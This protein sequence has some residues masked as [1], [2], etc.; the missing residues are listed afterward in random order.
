MT[1][2]ETITFLGIMVALAAMPSTS[3][4]LVVT[5]SAT[6]GIGNG[7]AV[8]AGIVLG[9]L[10]FIMLALFGLS[11]VAETMGSLFMVVK[12][13][14]AMYLIWLGFLLL[15]TKNTTKIMI[16]RPHEKGN[17][18][19]SFVAGFTLTL[20]DIKAIFFYVSLLPMF[21]NLAALQVADIIVVVFVTV[22][23]VGGVKIVYALTSAKI[24]SLANNLK[25]DNAARK[26]A[27]GFMVGAGGYIIAKA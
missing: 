22:A 3:V 12:Y 21:I 11:A 19:V 1:V 18:I 13:L 23:G 25:F 7:I 20:G 5:R 4:A 10:V 27:G 6:L 9:D 24:A 17:L 16:N 26:T 14:G 2:I 8:A 15:R